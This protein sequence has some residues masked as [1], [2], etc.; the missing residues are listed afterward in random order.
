M[1][2]SEAA[3]LDT[4]GV[5]RT[6]YDAALERERG[7]R[8]STLKSLDSA[9]YVCFMQELRGVI[10]ANN[11]TVVD[12]SGDASF[13]VPPN[14]TIYVYFPH[15]VSDALFE[16]LFQVKL[17]EAHTSRKIA[18]ACMK[19][20]GMGGKGMFAFIGAEMLARE[21]AK[22]RAAHGYVVTIT[23]AGRRIVVDTES[24][25]DKDQ[26]AV[27][28]V[29][30]NRCPVCFTDNPPNNNSCAACQRFLC[31]PCAKKTAQCPFCRSEALW[32]RGL[33]QMHV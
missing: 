23:A 24:L 25:E 20:Y 32:F 1:S 6:E 7:E 16:E 28:F 8:G 33:D 14:G 4:Y 5:S 17:A 9:D 13:S 30:L 27:F 26:L 12:K 18:N 21:R 15:A 2:E 22:A 10:G 31:T 11:I 19:K 3:L 29:D